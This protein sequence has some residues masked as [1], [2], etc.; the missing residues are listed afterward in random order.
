MKT[1]TIAQVRRFVLNSMSSLQ[2]GDKVKLSK[3]ELGWIVEEEGWLTL[4]YTQ[5]EEYEVGFIRFRS[6][7]T[8]SLPKSFWPFDFPKIPTFELTVYHNQIDEEFVKNLRDFVSFVIVD[9]PEI[10]TWDIFEDFQSYP[11]YGW[12]KKARD[13]YQEFK[14]KSRSN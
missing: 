7:M 8:H 13:L 11:N 5:I 4:R 10:Y 2:G 1:Q 3:D 6:D 14:K 12:T 9:R